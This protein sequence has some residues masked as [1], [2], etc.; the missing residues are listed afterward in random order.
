MQKDTFLEG[1]I[2]PPLV[3][4][5]LPLMLSLIL[6]ALYGAVDL[7]VVGKF[8]ETSSVS[9]VATGSQ[10]MQTATVIVTGLTMGV[11][12][13]IGQAIGSDNRKLAGEIVAGQIKL[14]TIVAI[15]LT[16]VMVAFAEKAAVIM[17]VPSAALDD[18]V[19][20]IRICS[21]GMVFITAYNAIS[22]V[23]RGLGNS[24]SPFIFVS[25]ACVIN[26]IGDLILVGV[27]D[28]GAAG[29]AAATVLAQACSVVFSLFYMRRISLPF[30]VGRGDFKVRGPV[31][32]IL[33]IGSPIAL[34]DFLVSISFLIITSVIN[35]LGVTASA[36]VGIAEKLYAFLS[37]VPMSFMSALSA[38]VAQNIGAKQPERAV[39]SLF[40]AQRISFCFGV[41]MFIMTFFFGDFLSSIFTS[42]PDVIRSTAEYL[43]GCSFEYLMIPIVFCFLG[44]FNGLGKTGFVMAQGLMSSFLVR[45]PLSYVL[46]RLENTTMLIISAAVPL[47]AVASLIICLVFFMIIRKR[48]RRRK[49]TGLKNL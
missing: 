6:Q 14:F 21:S 34:Q 5:A 46:S 41:V 39:K 35:A 45:V 42:D 29:A 4:F 38:F 2:T 3:K 8:C 36:S 17:N 33:K 31:R 13:L 26:I 22:G 43:R 18:A 32:D 1:R 11:T 23:F 44:Y 25:I 12:V 30:S 16:V 10:V 48:A 15:A 47:S 40:I 27:F 37:I 24:R 49:Y 28:M 7:A 19:E 20:Y 9:A